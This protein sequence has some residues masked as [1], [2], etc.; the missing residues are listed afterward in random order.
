MKHDTKG[1]D[2][3]FDAY[4]RNDGIDPAF[5]ADLRLRLPVAIAAT[6]VAGTLAWGWFATRRAHPAPPELPSFAA[7]LQQI[8]RMNAVQ[9]E[10]TVTFASADKS[11]REVTA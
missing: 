3:L 2:N 8:Q 1:P 6:L 4:D 5:Q 10:Q 9:Y 11:A 7:V